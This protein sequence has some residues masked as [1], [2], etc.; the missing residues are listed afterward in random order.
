MISEVKLNPQTIAVELET[1]PWVREEEGGKY[2]ARFTLTLD[3]ADE[4]VE[5]LEKAL[6]EA[7][8]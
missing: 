5:A 8:H 4:L 7:Q 6:Y 1:I 2:M 3:E